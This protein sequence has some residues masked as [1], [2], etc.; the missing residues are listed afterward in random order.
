MPFPPA[1]LHSIAGPDGA[2][3]LDVE[4]D[5]MITLN[6]TGG[7]VWERL[8]R[9]DM[10]EAIVHELVSETKADVAIVEADIRAFIEE[11]KA[12]RLLED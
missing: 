5:A 8:Q 9:G 6:F 10:L 12:K 3:I 1:H 4:H 2:A 11:L 7:F